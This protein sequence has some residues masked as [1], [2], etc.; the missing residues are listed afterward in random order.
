MF[1]LLFCVDC[2]LSFVDEFSLWL[3]IWWLELLVRSK[4]K[5]WVC[6]VFRFAGCWMRFPLFVDAL[7]YII[8]TRRGRFLGGH[9]PASDGLVLART[10]LVTPRWA[11]SAHSSPVTAHPWRILWGNNKDI[12]SI[13][14]YTFIK[15]YWDRGMNLEMI[16]WWSTN[17]T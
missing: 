5:N 3:V 17:S 10:V 8:L 7:H 9:W 11:Y 1:C 14:L 15:G 4:P 16:K 12:F 13:K 2:M 6:F